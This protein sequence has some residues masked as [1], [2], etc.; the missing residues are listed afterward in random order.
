MK[1]VLAKDELV[2]IADSLQIEQVL[3]N[4][5][6]NARDAMPR[7]GTFTIETAKAALDDRFVLQEPGL[8]PGNYAVMTVADSGIGMDDAMRKKIFEPFFTTKEVGKGSGLGLAMVYGIVKQHN[9]HIS[10]Y[11]EPGKGTSFRIYLPLAATGA[12]PQLAV[13]EESGPAP[14]GAETILIGEDD[15]TVRTM[16]VS[17]LR[18]CGYTVI[19]AEDG[20]EVINKFIEQRDRIDLLILDVIMPKK[21]GR[22][23]YDVVKDIKPGVKV[24]FTSGYT[25]DFMHTR[26]ILDE[27]LYFVQKPISTDTLLRAIRSVVNGLPPSSLR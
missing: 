20:E 21:S 8:K 1:S 11:S 15:S 19:E 22:E 10:V 4:L 23:V 16:T 18:E 14:C 26:E 17:V 5:A 2:L 7:G 3:M 27:G 9:G 25:A 12:R 24:L 6:T 13:Q